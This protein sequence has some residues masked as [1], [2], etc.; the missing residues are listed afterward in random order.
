[1]LTNRLIGEVAPLQLYLSATVF[2]L[3]NRIVRKL[4]AQIPTWIQQRPITLS[5]WSLELQKLEGHTLGVSAVAFSP[6]G[7]LLASASYDRTVRLW[8]PKTGQEAQKLEDVEYNN[9]ISF[10]VDNKSLL[11]DRGCYGIDSAYTSIMTL[12]SSLR[13]EHGWIKYHGRNLLWLPQEYRSSELALY[14]NTLAFGQDSGTVS[15]LQVNYP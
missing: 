10:T 8:N 5:T 1:M 15:F 7:L 6:D 12:K 3:Q 11:T 14:N 13:L 9:R 2:A 4:Y